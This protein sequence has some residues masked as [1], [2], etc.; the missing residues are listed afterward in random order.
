L[1]KD[2]LGADYWVDLNQ[3]A[4]RDLTDENAGQ[5]DLSTPNK[6]IKEGDKFS[7]NYDIHVNYL[8]AF[9]NMEYKLRNNLDAYAGVSLSSTSFWRDGKWQN[10]AF[11]DNSLGE[12]EKQKFTN[13]MVKAGLVYKVTGRHLV[14]VN[15]MY[16]TRAPM[17]AN[18]FTSPRTRNEVVDNLT[19][20]QVMSG[21]INYIVRY[22]KLKLRLSGFYSEINN[23]TWS[24]NFYHDEYRTFVNYMMSDVD[25]LFRGLEF[26]F[27]QSL[28]SKWQVTGAFTTAQYLYNNRPT[29]KIVRDNARDVV[30]E[31]RLIYLKNYKI[32]GMPQTAGTIGLKYNSP[33]YWW[34]AINFNYLADIYLDPN[35]DRR[36]TESLDRY[37]TDDPQVAKIIDQE[38]LDNGYTVNLSFGKSW[39]LKNS[40]QIRVNAN[41]NNLFNNR[42]FITGGF[43]QL[44]Y[45]AGDIDRFPP[46]LG[47]AIGLNYFVMVTYQ[48]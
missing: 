24:R 3:F 34:A 6:I 9:G 25:Q 15:G 19:D 14:T 32:G 38:K 30:A 39:R 44:R 5:N 36:T 17:V 22:P 1:M 8:E 4:E 43:E 29:S 31:D 20:I 10:A 48:M 11:A 12:S 26:G 42:D 40:N 2:L 18:A 35:P 41:I 45:D 16:G 37:V 33:K 13:Y 27:E 21:D 28:D 47:Y 46:K 23:Q 7:Y